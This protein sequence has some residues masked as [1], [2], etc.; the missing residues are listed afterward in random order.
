M[1]R[2]KH[3]HP[4]VCSMVMNL[5]SNKGEFRHLRFFQVP[6]FLSRMAVNCLVVSCKSYL[7]SEL[8]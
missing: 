3:K 5:A 1:L 6:F 4:Y 7:R 2:W 8:I